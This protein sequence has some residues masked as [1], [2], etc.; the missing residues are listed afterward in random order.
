MN[1]DGSNKQRVFP[2]QG[3]AGIVNPQAVWSGDGSQILVIQEGNIYL[4]DAGGKGAVQLTADGG[5]T[6]VRWR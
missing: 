6:A 1:V 2:E 4:V 3:G 5:G